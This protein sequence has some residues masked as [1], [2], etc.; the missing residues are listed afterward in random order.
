[1]IL[2]DLKN[3]VWYQKCH[4]PVCKAQNFKSTCSPLPTEVSL[5]FLL[6]DED[7]TSGETDDTSTS[8]TKD[9]QTPP[10]CNLSAGGLSAAAWDDEDDA[11]FLEATEDAEFADAADKSLGSMDDIPDELIIEALQNS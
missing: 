2:V 4:D 9:S 10:S 11:L 1:M 5:L 8:L 6:K 7:F 3:E